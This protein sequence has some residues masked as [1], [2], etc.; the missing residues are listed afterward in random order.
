MQRQVLQSLANGEVEVKTILFR[1]VAITQLRAHRVEIRRRKQ[2]RLEI[3]ETPVRLTEPGVDFDTLAV[4]LDALVLMAG[5]LER[6]AVTHPCLGV[7][8]IFR[9]DLGIDLNGSG[10]LA[11][12]AQD[13]CLEVTIAWIL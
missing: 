5:G 11:D 9:Q 3:G 7:T 2:K 1:E 6:M 12:R 13:R 10:V 8:R 4:G